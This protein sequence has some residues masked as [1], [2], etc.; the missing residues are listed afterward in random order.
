MTTLFFRGAAV[1]VPIRRIRRKRL[2]SAAGFL[3]VA[4]LA[5]P[6]CG[7]LAFELTLLA[8]AQGRGIRVLRR[9]R[10]PR[11]ASSPTGRAWNRLRP[12]LL[13]PGLA[14]ASLP[15][16]AFL[17]LLLDV[18]GKRF[19]AQSARPNRV[20]RKPDVRLLRG[21]LPRLGDRGLAPP[22]NG[23]SL[24]VGLVRSGRRGPRPLRRR[25]LRLRRHDLR[26]LGR[27]RRFLLRR[28][29][30]AVPGARAAAD[31]LVD[32][33]RGVGWESS[34]R[35]LAGNTGILPAIVPPAPR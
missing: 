16:F 11:R 4:A 12:A 10:A 9:H 13:S 27:R 29:A 20:Q 26:S 1:F 25:R 6:G 34:A 14:E 3:F 30:S 15:P 21:R 32:F 24:I 7:S 31:D 33:R 35:R 2:A 22:G 17:L 8:T 18:L 23:A 5:S 28:R 19:L